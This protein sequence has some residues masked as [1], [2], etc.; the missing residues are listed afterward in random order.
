MQRLFW[1]HPNPYTKEKMRIKTVKETKY[2]QAVA[3]LKEGFA[4]ME[5]E[6]KEKDDAI[7][8]KIGLSV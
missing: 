5:N 1:N 6:E 4:A 8:Q 7:V 3:A 2:A